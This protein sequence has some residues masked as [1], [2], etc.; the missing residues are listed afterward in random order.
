MAKHQLNP[1]AQWRLYFLLFFVALLALHGGSARAQDVLPADDSAAQATITLTPSDD[2][3]ISSLQPTDNFGAKADLRVAQQNRAFETTLLR[4]DLSVFPQ[5][6]TVNR[7]TLR[8]FQTAFVDGTPSVTL[9]VSQ[10]F[11]PWSED[12]VTWETA[13]TV[14]NVGADPLLSPAEANVAVE[15]DVTNLV[16]AWV[17]NPVN[18]ANYGL[19]VEPSV[20]SAAFARTFSSKEGARAPQLIIDYDLPPIRICREQIDSCPAA[21]GAI[22]TVVG[23]QGQRVAD[24]T[25][26]VDSTGLAL[27]QQVWVRWPVQGSNGGFLYHTLPQ[28]VTLD[29]SRFIFNGEGYEIRLAVRSTS[30]LWVQNL[31]VSAQWYVQGSAAEAAAL[32]SR[33]LRASNFLYSFTDGQ[34]ALGQVTVRQ[35]YDAWESAN[36]QLYA[37]NVLQPKA[38]IGGVSPVETPDF[39]PTVPITYS[40]GPVSIGSYWNRFGSPPN[41][42]NVFEG[43]TY[44]EAAMADDW[45]LALAHEF[46]HYLLYL[47]DT[48]TGVDGV[49]DLALTKLCTGSAMGDVY[50]A[51]NQ[52]FIF[53]PAHWNT[54]CNGTEAHAAPQWPH[55]VADDP[56]LV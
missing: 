9:P 26:F 56:G 28:P 6:I 43:T 27:G 3:T 29:G 38:I 12:G 37:S 17:N 44:T 51:E 14:D 36:V 41:S 7:A 47:F 52:N 46:G 11:S 21:A 30:P 22:L 31:A 50:R 2:A 55:R 16:N 45:S 33:I 10:I 34:F 54:R 19:Q 25:G 42:V 8:L 1:R 32:R 23:A 39:A 18:G 13:P 48:Y 49:A 40:N 15:G 35:S 24:A 5:G 53:D 4:F 20:D